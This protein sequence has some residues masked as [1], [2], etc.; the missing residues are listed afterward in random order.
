MR[1]GLR[2]ARAGASAHRPACAHCPRARR[3]WMRRSGALLR[4]RG[5]MCASLPKVWSSGRR[6]RPAVAT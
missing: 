3:V 5:S 4:R 6:D 2:A 1:R